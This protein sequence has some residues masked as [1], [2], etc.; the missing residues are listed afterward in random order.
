MTETFGTRPSMARLNPPGLPEPMGY[1]QV[2]VAQ[3]TRIVHVS[4]QVGLDSEGELLG[5]DLRTQ[6]EQAMRNLRLALE[7]AGVAM[8]EVAKM[9]FFIIDLGPEAMGP[10]FEASAAVF[11]AQ[12]SMTAVTMI[13]VAALADPRLKIEVEATAVLTG[14]AAAA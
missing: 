7:S 11:G 5:P 4:G 9:T 6:A 10:L 13:G 1:C 12:P 8:D 2:T 14:K 3:G